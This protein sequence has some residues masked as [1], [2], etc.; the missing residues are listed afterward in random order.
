MKIGIIGGGAAGFFTAITCAEANPNAAV[1][2][3]ERG[4]D[5]LQKVKVSGGGRCNVTH[6]CPN[7]AELVK[8]YPRGS[9]ELLAPF[10]RFGTAHTVAWFG[11][12]GV[13]TKVE[14]DGRMFPVSNSSQTI[15]DCLMQAA[16]NANI[17]IKTGVRVSAIQL[18]DDAKWQI[19]ANG[20]VFIYDKL[21]VAAGSANA[22]WELLTAVGHTVI[23]P[24]PSLF[25]FNIK[26]PRLTGLLGISVPNATLKLEQTKLQTEGALLIT[27]WGLSG[28][29]ALRLSAWGAHELA[30]VHYK[31]NIR[32]NW[33]GT[34]KTDEAVAV[35]TEQKD[36]N[37]RKKVLANAQFELSTRLWQRLV[38]TVGIAETVQWADMS[39]KT[40]LS[41]AEQL[42]NGVFAV[43]GK[44]TFKEE[45]VTAGGVSLKEVNFKTF[46]SKLFP[47]LYFAGEILNIDA[48]TGGFNF[49]AA[50]TAGHI[51]GLAMAENK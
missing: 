43:N 12:R 1:M 3:L 5:V 10:T 30:D 20:S 23:K 17:T 21:M 40:I 45:F 24:V 47:N 29:A 19:T 31:T 22:V 34:L 41:L 32:V 44:S 35:L 16:F 37:P 6:N 26:D 33:L 38:T 28:P 48:I 27:H 13:K 11:Q 36:L 46:E 39:K 2:I 14:S 18:L 50:W 9:K 4:G 42:T 25:S 8:H 7:V 15:I 51:A 49:Q